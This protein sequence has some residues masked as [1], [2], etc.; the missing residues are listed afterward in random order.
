MITFWVIPE[1][2]A[3]LDWSVN[4]YSM[5]KNTNEVNELGAISVVN[6]QTSL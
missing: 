6:I 5:Q 3:R 2:K 1:S 4:I